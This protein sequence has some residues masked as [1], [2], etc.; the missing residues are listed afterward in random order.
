MHGRVALAAY[1]A[2]VP[3]GDESGLADRLI[4]TAARVL[5]EEGAP[6]LSARRLAREC[7]TSTMAVYTHHGSMEQLRVAVRRK[8][9]LGLLAHLE[10][11]EPSDDPVAD[12]CRI[13]FAYGE[14]ARAND[15]LFRATFFEGPL[16]LD[17]LAAGGDAFRPI[18]RAVERCLEDGRFAPAPAAALALACWTAAH[19]AAALPLT[20]LVEP[21]MAVVTLAGIGEALFIGFGDEPGRARASV[22]RA[23]QMLPAASGG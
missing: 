4:E 19:G 11:A 7:G 6:A 22:A 21:D 14:Y 23:R 20:G 10:E 12:V 1:A 16:E 3:A 8:A 5:A 17:D 9:F 13:G 18:V 15:A 2:P